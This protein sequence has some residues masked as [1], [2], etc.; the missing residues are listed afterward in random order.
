MYMKEE[1]I[2]KRF[3]KRKISLNVGTIICYLITGSFV[4]G[5]DITEN[6]TVGDN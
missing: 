4:F 1:K 3:L 6:K 2:L 5:Q